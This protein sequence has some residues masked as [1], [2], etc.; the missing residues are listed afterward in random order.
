MYIFLICTVLEVTEEQVAEQRAYVESLE[1]KGHIVY[2]PHRDIKQDDPEHGMGICRDTFWQILWAKEVH[3]IFDP[4]IVTPDGY[5]MILLA[6]NELGKS[7]PFRKLITRRRVVIVNPEE[8]DKRIK[9][10]TEQQ[11][12]NGVIP[13]FVKSYT[14]VLKNLAN[15][16]VNL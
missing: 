11:I 1:T 3:V 12:S 7:L 5:T 13:S 14:M 10:E 15:E 2:W 8:V 9:E 16:T 4:E 6:L